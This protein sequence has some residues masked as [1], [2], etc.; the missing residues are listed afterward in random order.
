MKVLGFIAALLAVSVVAA[1]APQDPA[2]PNPVKPGMYKCVDARGVTQYTD[3]QL[4]GCKGREVNIQGQ[5]PVSGALAPPPGSLKREEQAFQR[6]RIAEERSR[7]ENVKAHEQQAQRCAAL[8][9]ELRRLES[10]LRL[11]RPD[12]SGGYEYIEDGERAQ[13]AAQLQDEIAQKCR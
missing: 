5:P 3:R 11:V 12:A 10:G 1:Q 9:G 7:E 8:Q 13:R 2:S 4:P 6:R